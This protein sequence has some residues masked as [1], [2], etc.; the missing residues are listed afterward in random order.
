M[1]SNKNIIDLLNG[2]VD[3]DNKLIRT[4]GDSVE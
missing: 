3:I 1:D 2:R 4:V